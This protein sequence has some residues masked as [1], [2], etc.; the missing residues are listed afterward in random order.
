MTDGRDHD[1]RRFLALAGLAGVTGLSG[2]VSTGGFEI[3]PMGDEEDG[4]TPADRDRQL[5][6][7]YSISVEQLRS[8][9]YTNQS[10]PIEGEVVR[11]G[12]TGG[13][14][15]SFSLQDET[16]TLEQV[17]LAE[18]NGTVGNGDQV[19]LVGT[20]RNGTDDE[21]R[22]VEAEIRAFAGASATETATPT[23]DGN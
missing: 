4:G 13:D 22:I 23:T 2:C 1:R 8:G 12:T 15:T 21:V 18:P 19:R 6:G 11:A 5:S 14:L 7:S 10:V 20:V 3:G 17:D 16:G 9:N